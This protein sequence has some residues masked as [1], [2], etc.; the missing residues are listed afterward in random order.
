VGT[1]GVESIG[2]EV[3][4]V[5]GEIAVD[6]DQGVA[7]GGMPEGTVE[8]TAQGLTAGQARKYVI[9]YDI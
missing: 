9:Q 1:Q 5:K 2:D 7:V 4:E 3:E 6:S 8:R